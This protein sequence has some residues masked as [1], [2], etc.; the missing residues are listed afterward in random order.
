MT[1]R[2][3][4]PRQDETFSSLSFDLEKIVL[5]SLLGDG[6]CTITKPYTNARYQ[7]R[8]SIKQ[9]EYFLWKISQFSEISSPN[10]LWYNK[11][12]TKIRYCSRALPELTILSNLTYQKGRKTLSRKWLNSL[13]P[14][15]L[16]IL[17]CDDGSLISNTMKGVFCLDNFSFN[18]QL[19]FVTYLQKVWGIEAKIYQTNKNYYRTYLNRENLIKFLRL[20]LP[21]IPVKSMLYKAT[22]LYKDEVLQQRWISEMQNLTSFSLIEIVELIESRKAQLKYFRK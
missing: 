2:K 8:H 7:E 5:G 9:E 6:C 16:A 17:W 13:T 18:E 14:L 15:S 19:L 22:L 10:H 12:R 4:P 11:S 1:D 20:I 21:Y 3:K